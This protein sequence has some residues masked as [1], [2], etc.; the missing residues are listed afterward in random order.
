VASGATFGPRPRDRGLEATA[1][2]FARDDAGV[3][4]FKVGHL[5]FPQPATTE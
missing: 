4:Q 5:Q 3:L 1:E 2:R